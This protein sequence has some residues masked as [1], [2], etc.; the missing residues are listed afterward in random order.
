VHRPGVTIIGAHARVAPAVATPYNAFTTERNRQTALTL[1]QD[2]SLP[3]D[4]LISHRIRPD[5]ALP[6][7]RAL[8][9]RAPGYMGVVVD[10]A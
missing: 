2:G 7:Y 1:I 6:T 8:A 5:E 3:V 9:D 4:G 10:W